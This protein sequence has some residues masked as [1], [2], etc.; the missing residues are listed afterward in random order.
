MFLKS[1]PSVFGYSLLLILFGCSSQ[2]PECLIVSPETGDRFKRGDEVNIVV[3]ASDEDGKIEQI[4]ILLDGQDL[5]TLT[6]IPYTFV[7]HTDSI[8]YGEHV[9]TVNAIDNDD[10]STSNNILISF[11]EAPMVTTKAVSFTNPN[12]VKVD[13]TIDNFS[14]TIFQ[15]GFVFS[16]QE[17]LIPLEQY[18]FVQNHTG[19]QP[20]E[21]SL[22]YQNINSTETMHYRAY[23][24]DEYGN[25]FS[26]SLSCPQTLMT[27]NF[28]DN[29]RDWRT[30]P[31]INEGDT[32]L[33][34]DINGGY[35]KIKGF[36]DN[37]FFH[38]WAFINCDLTRD[39][40]LEST[41]SFKEGEEC[42][43]GLLYHKSNSITEIFYITND[44]YV[45]VSGFGEEYESIF[46]TTKIK[47]INSN[48]TN[49]LQVFCFD[50]GDE[51][52]VYYVVNGQEIYNT[53]RSNKNQEQIFGFSIMEGMAWIDDLSI[54]YLDSSP[55]NSKSSFLHRGD[56]SN[57]QAPKN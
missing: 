9:L 36:R 18:T 22:E 52:H 2:S 38:S 7:W 31:V 8:S 45:R 32:T 30:G 28:E 4:N 5:G 54:K 57:E 17:E 14:G 35:Y 40:V 51:D 26:E 42:H 16:P 43:V 53:L 1:T 34:F 19:L 3:N 39:F 56:Y 6:S 55:I 41:L 50:E 46:N 15:S 25:G 13:Y 20:R 21:Q 37:T 33:R 23:A 10:N 44:G 29:L 48:G 24:S 47:E 49:K 12:S 11:M 27:D